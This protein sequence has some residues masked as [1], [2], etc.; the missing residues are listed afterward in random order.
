[1]TSELHRTL[2]RIGLNTSEIMAIE[3]LGYT[4]I[5]SMKGISEQNLKGA[6]G[7]IGLP[8]GNLAKEAILRRFGKKS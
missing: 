7:Y 1:M 6:T 5:R 2:V 4:S 3:R 8:I